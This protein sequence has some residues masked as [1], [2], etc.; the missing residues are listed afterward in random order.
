MPQSQAVPP[1]GPLA[2]VTSDAGPEVL[3]VSVSSFDPEQGWRGCRYATSPANR[4]LL[5]LVMPMG[6]STGVSTIS[7][8]R[9]ILHDPSRKE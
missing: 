3:N 5:S 1:G 2:S 9:W 8:R 4:M 6:P 7:G